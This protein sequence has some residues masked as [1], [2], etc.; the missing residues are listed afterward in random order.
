MNR[1]ALTALILFAACSDE[2]TDDELNAAAPCR[3]NWPGGTN[4][5]LCVPPCADYGKVTPDD[6]CKIAADDLTHGGPGVCRGGGIGSVEYKGVRGCCFA[7]DD[8]MRCADE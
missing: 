8:F 4:D 7:S 6:T 5:D 3:S 2:P 1:A